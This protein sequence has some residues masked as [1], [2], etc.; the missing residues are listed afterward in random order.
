M[1]DWRVRVAWNHHD[2]FHT[3]HAEGRYGSRRA[4]YDVDGETPGEPWTAEQILGF[5]CF[6]VVE[7]H[8][9]QEKE[10]GMTF[11]ITTKYTNI[12]FGGIRRGWWYRVEY[13]NLSGVRKTDADSGFDT[14][15]NAKK[16]AEV[17]C[18]DLARA[19]T[20]DETYL[21]TPEV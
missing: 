15:D 10:A 3:W 14:R 18:R 20:P 21:Y 12:S 4:R 17:R 19:M 13:E 9:Q 11:K 2:G 16:A 7:Q 8:Q 5:H 1:G 6:V